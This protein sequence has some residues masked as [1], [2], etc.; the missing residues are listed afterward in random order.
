MKE[1]VF[2]LELS[3]P[4]NTSLCLTGASLSAPLSLIR[5]LE[6]QT[7]VKQAARACTTG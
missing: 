2:L 1:S 5:K 7:F 6:T 3:K 4:M